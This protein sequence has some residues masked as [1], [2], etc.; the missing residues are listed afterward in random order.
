[1][2]QQG[3]QFLQRIKMLVL[4]DFRRMMTSDVLPLQVVLRQLSDNFQVLCCYFAANLYLGDSE[5]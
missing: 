1:M 2:Q 3:S 4:G 5:D